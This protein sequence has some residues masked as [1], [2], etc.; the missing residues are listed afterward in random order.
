V[1]EDDDGISASL[2]QV[3][4]EHGYTVRR[5]ADAATALQLAAAEQPDLVLL[6]LGLP[7]ADGLDLCRRLVS[8]LRGTR[9]IMLTARDAEID[10]VIGLDA[11]AA[12]YITKPFSLAELLARVRTHVR[13][14]QGNVAGP[15]T[16]GRLT[17]DPASRRVWADGVEVE[18]RNLELALLTSLAS[19]A[20]EVVTRDQLMAEVW[21]EH[22]YGSTKRLDVHMAALRRK[23]GEAPGEPSCITTI[24]GVGYRL[25]AG[26]EAP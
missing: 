20:G 9:V 6:D 25:D 4:S 1:I 15:I 14:S 21:D 2:V 5:A 18:L 12:D 10:V 23:L 16:A 13:R 26:T 19:R 8:E 24:R 11:G 17:I 22:W 3:L 7:D